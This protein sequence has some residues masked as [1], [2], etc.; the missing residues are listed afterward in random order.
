M[1]SPTYC[2]LSK[3][4]TDRFSA[5][6]TVLIGLENLGPTPCSKDRSPPI[7]SAVTKISENKIAASTPNRSI[8]S[9]VT[10]VAISG[11]LH[12]SKKEYLFFISQYSFINLPACRI[13]HTGGRSVGCEKAALINKL[14][15]IAVV[16]LFW[17]FVF[18]SIYNLGNSTTHF[19]FLHLF[20]IR[21]HPIIVFLH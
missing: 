20:Q 10:S 3:Q 12:I 5:S 11:V 13:I 8:G 7:A 4:S 21:L 2:S 9:M 19:Q 16:T 18:Y 1:A 6:C 14:S 17:Y 15:F